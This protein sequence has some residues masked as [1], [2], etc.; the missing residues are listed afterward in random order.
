MM[1]NYLKGK[2]LTRKRPGRGIHSAL[3]LHTEGS[4]QKEVM[5]F[6]RPGGVKAMDQ[7]LSN[8]HGWPLV[9]EIHVCNIK[10]CSVNLPK[11][12]PPAQNKV[13]LKY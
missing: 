11:F 6:E 5:V 9:I 2:L 12:T 13:Q 8:S 4:A 10:H 7:R 1:A 3:V